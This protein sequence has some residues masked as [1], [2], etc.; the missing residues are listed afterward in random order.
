MPGATPLPHAIVTS[1]AVSAPI[2]PR[3]RDT[4]NSSIKDGSLTESVLLTS[5]S[6]FKLS[7]TV[8]DGSSPV[9]PQQAYIV[10]HDAQYEDVQD[11]T[12][13]LGVKPNGKATYY[14][15]RPPPSLTTH[16]H[17]PSPPLC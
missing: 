16:P 12:L 7:F 10:F 2:S 13:A 8:T 9:L 3:P 4:A 15:V 5:G 14:L 11:V 17:P 1:Q 6:T